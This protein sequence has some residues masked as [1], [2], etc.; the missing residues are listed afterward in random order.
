MN[1]DKVGGASL[2]EHS[3]GKPA[4][5]LPSVGMTRCETLSAP[6]VIPTAETND[7]A[8]RTTIQLVVVDHLRLCRSQVGKSWVAGPGSGTAMKRV[9]QALHDPASIVS[10]SGMTFCRHEW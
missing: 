8:L 4:S 5:V 9:G 3:V 2:S 7:V 10:P 1:T 6:G